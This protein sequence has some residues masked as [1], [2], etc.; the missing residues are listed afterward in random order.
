MK[1]TVFIAH[2]LLK[3]ADGGNRVSDFA[4]K[5]Y[6]PVATVGRFLGDLYGDYQDYRKYKASSSRRP[7]AVQLQEDRKPV[8]VTQPGARV[9]YDSAT[10]PRY[11]RTLDDLAWR[12]REALQSKLHEAADDLAYAHSGIPDADN[13]SRRRRALDVAAKASANADDTWLFG[14][15]KHGVSLERQM[16]DE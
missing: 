8:K 5:V 2:Q 4:K 1:N 7:T 6:K 11:Y 9:Y 15:H 16:S 10:D 3:Q 12:R 13:I 14:K